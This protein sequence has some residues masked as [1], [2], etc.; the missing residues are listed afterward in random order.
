MEDLDG[1]AQTASP[2]GIA[3]H[4]VE[5]GGLRLC[6]DDPQATLRRVSRFGAQR[7]GN[8]DAVLVF[9]HPAD[10]GREELGTQSAPVRPVGEEYGK[11]H[12]QEVS[13]SG[14][15][16]SLRAQRERSCPGSDLMKSD[17]I[18]T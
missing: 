3:L 18:L 4:E 15:S 12:L 6:F 17:F 16:P 1:L 7:P 2:E 9:L 8:Q 14:L 13:R 5:D 10:V 11:Q